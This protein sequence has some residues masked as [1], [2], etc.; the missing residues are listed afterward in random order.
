M[1]VIGLIPCTLQFHGHHENC[2]YAPASPSINTFLFVS[3]ICIDVRRGSLPLG[4]TLDFFG[5]IWDVTC[6]VLC[7]SIFASVSLLV[8]YSALV[9]KSEKSSF[10]FP[11]AGRGFD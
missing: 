8:G 10:A 6:L 7:V 1:Q 4:T 3:L 9:R 11:P 2:I 5:P